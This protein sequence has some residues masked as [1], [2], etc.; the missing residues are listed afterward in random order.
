MQNLIFPQINIMEHPETE[1]IKRVTRDLEKKFKVINDPQ[2][3]K[4]VNFTNTNTEPIHGWF[5]Y[6]E[7]FSIYLLDII[8]QSEDSNSIICDPFCGCGTTLLGAKKYGLKSFGM[9]INPLAVF[10]SKVKTHN[11]NQADIK[12]IERCIKEISGLQSSGTKAKLPEL[13][14][15]GRVFLPEILEFLLVL[16][17]Y[18]NKQSGKVHDFLLLGWISVLESVS[19]TYKEGNGIKYKNKKRTPKGYIT[20]PDS[21]WQSKYF[22]SADRIAF[23]RKVFT[24]KLNTMILDVEKTRLSREV[25]TVLEADATSENVYYMK[26]IG[27]SI[28]SPPYCNCF[29]Y[30]EIFK[31]ELWMG[32]FINSYEELKTL[33]R[34]ALRSNVNAGIGSNSL[35]QILVVDT[36]V[37]LIDRNAVWDS[38]LPMVVKGYFSD[39]YKV[40]KNLCSVTRNNGKC[41][42]VVGNSAYGGVL[43]PTDIIL[44]ELAASIGFKVDAIRI[45]RHLTTSS[46]QKVML[47]SLKPYLRE[48]LVCLSKV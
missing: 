13:K 30:F 34:K 37:N 19:N 26:D 27:L 25:P 29:D 36:L 9:D 2:F 28:F 32:G 10:V 11:Y 12:Q 22:P 5:K 43:I 21:E 33:R 20:L 35:V 39:M 23:V 6:R 41:I 4:L 17:A 18:I 40:L 7:G 47:D 48:S 46:Q 14:I 38:R 31:I 1:F 42:I 45:A 24:E 44:A 15:L 3:A 16:K 8:L